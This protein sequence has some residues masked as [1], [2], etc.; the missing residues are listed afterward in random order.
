MPRIHRY[1]LACTILLFGLP[2][3]LLHADDELLTADHDV[4]GVIDHYVD[5]FESFDAET[6]D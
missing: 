5:A 3:P 2:V 6:L 1:V 4:A